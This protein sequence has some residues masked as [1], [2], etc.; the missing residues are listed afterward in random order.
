MIQKAILKKIFEQVKGYDFGVTYWDGTQDLFGKTSGHSELDFEIIFNEKLDLQKIK[1]SPQ[2]RL[3]E[4]YMDGE[5]DVKG[6]LRE[7][8][9]AGAK[10]VS[11]F[12]NQGTGKDYESFMQRQKETSKNEQQDGVRHH[13]DLGNDFFELWHDDTMTYSCAYF[14]NRDDSLKDAQ[15]QKIDHIL[16]KLNLSSGEKLLDIGCGWGELVLRA[17]E[18]YDVNVLGITISDEQVKGAREKVINRDLTDKVEI[19]KKDYRD[20]AD[21]DIE[22]D[23]IV[24]V[25]MFEHV[26]K[27]NIPEYFQTVNKLLKDGGLSLLHTITHQKE[28]PTHPWLE[29]YIFP[30]GYIPSYR[31]VVWQLPEHSFSLIDAENIRRHYALTGERWADNFAAS[32]DEVVEKFDERFARM[33]ELFLA[34]VVATFRYLNTSVHQ[35]LFVKG[36]NNDRPLT[37]DYM[38]K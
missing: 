34:G 35:F 25:G 17:A 29:K 9:Q 23:K 14:K 18:K 4:A 21:E 22:F 32:R 1:E 19:R 37:R 16:N 27:D 28:D 12:K 38:Y 8:L 11:R 15:L 7:V 2:L 3:G 26:G 24:S 5:I 36:Y 31:E 10:N 13:Y 30:W 6:D 20:L 33:W